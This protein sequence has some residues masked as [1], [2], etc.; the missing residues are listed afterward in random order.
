MSPDFIK[1]QLR[2][3]LTVDLS[4]Y[5]VSPVDFSHVGKTETSDAVSNNP[6]PDLRTWSK[7]FP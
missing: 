5:N 2:H 1:L 7:C 4:T 6:F 3:I